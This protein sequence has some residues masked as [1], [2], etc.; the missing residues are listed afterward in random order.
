MLGNGRDVTSCFMLLH[1]SL[2][3]QLKHRN[4]LNDDTFG[5]FSVGTW[6]VFQSGHASSCDIRFRYWISCVD[7]NCDTTLFVSEIIECR[8]VH[9]LVQTIMI[10]SIQGTWL[11]ICYIQQVF[12]ESWFF[13]NK[14]SLLWMMYKIWLINIYKSTTS[15]RVMQLDDL[16][17]PKFCTFFNNQIRKKFTKVVIWCIIRISIEM[18]VTKMG[19]KTFSNLFP[20]KYFYGCNI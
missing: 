15:S 3:V 5:T 20:H 12:F 6:L 1:N 9:Q 14:K 2:V 8:L 18:S 16:C 11:V 4:F 13:I 19:N 17:Y 7:F 10:F